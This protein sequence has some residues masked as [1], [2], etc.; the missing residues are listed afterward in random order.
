MPSSIGV[1]AKGAHMACEPREPPKLLK[2][3]RIEVKN[4]SS[5]EEAKVWIVINVVGTVNPI[6]V[7]TITSGGIRSQGLGAKVFVTSNNVTATT[8]RL[9]PAFIIGPGPYLTMRR[10]EMF[11]ARTHPSVDE[12][13]NSPAV[14]GG[15]P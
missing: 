9:T 6:E 10:E 13:I 11:A 4:P 3:V 14:V 8:K 12:A 15:K 1:L 7:P 2:K 5:A